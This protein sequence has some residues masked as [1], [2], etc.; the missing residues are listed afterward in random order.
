MAMALSCPS[1][2]LNFVDQATFYGILAEDHSRHRD[3]M[4]SIGAKRRGCSRRERRLNVTHY[5][6]TSGE[7]FVLKSSIAM[8]SETNPMSTTVIKN[9]AT[10]RSL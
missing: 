10:V 2:T 1:E 4:M 5:H 8:S 9:G 6:P 3:T 7:P